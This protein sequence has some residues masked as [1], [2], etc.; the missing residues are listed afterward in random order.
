MHS[1][2]EAVWCEPCHRFEVQALERVEIGLD[3]DVWWG[4][5]QAVDLDLHLIPLEVEFWLQCDGDP[6][7]HHDPEGH[8][9][10]RTSMHSV[11]GAVCHDP[12]RRFESQA[13][14]STSEEVDAEVWDMT[15]GAVGVEVAPVRVGV[16]HELDPDFP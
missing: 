11:W 10:A 12:W 9:D 3:D 7:E 8:L 5:G 6:E 14:G 16:V 2:Y 1:V 15:I 4:T 13:H